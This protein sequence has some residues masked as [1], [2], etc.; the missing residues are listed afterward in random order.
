MMLNRFASIMAIT[1]LTSWD[2]LRRVSA[3]TVQHFER[4]DEDRHHE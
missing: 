3:R 2:A 1:V 4:W